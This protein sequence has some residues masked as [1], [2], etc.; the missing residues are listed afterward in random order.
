MD[1]KT[2]LFAIIVIVALFGMVTPIDFAMAQQSNMSPD[3]E[4]GEREGKSCPFKDKKAVSV[5]II[6]LI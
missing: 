4:D 6:S 1:S 3:G 2:A 5:G